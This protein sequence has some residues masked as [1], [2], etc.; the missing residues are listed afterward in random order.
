MVDLARLRRVLEGVLVLGL[1]HGP[2]VPELAAADTA[3]SAAEIRDEAERQRS[4]E[5]PSVLGSQSS[6]ILKVCAGQVPAGWIKTNDEWNPTVCGNPSTI[7]YNVWTIER[8]D[9]KPVNNVMTACEGAVPAGWAKLNGTWNPTRCGY[10]S[11]IV[12]NV[13]TIKRL[14]DSAVPTPPRNLQIR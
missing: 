9:N 8:Y 7:V 13:M 11:A 1:I 5:Q 3:P 6:D 2:V 12:N 4:L 14:A 10:P